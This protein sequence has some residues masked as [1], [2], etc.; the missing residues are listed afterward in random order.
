MLMYYYILMLSLFMLL[1]YKL[2]FSIGE[3]PENTQPVNTDFLNTIKDGLQKCLS[4]SIC[5]CIN[6]LFTA[7][8][9]L[10]FSQD[11]VQLEEHYFSIT[12]SIDQQQAISDFILAVF[13]A[14]STIALPLA[15]N[16]QT[17]AYNCTNQ[18]LFV[19]TVQA[20][21]ELVVF[22][23][24]L[25]LVDINLQVAISDITASP[26]LEALKL[27]GSVILGDIKFSTFVETK[28]PDM[29]YFGAI[30][31]GDSGNGVIKNGEFNLFNFISSV[32]DVELPSEPFGDLVIISNVALNGRMNIAA[33][34]DLILIIEATIHIGEWYDDRVCV[35]LH[36]TLQ[37]SGRSPPELAFLTGCDSF[38]SG[39]GLS[40]SE[41]VQGLIDIDISSVPFFGSLDLP[42]FHIV[43]T[44]PKFDLVGADFG[45]LELPDFG[46]L[47]IGD[48]SGFHF[49]F[50]FHIDSVNLPW[51]ISYINGSL[52]LKPLSLIKGFSISDVLKAISSTVSLPDVDVI[53]SA[54]DG[55]LLTNLDLDVE[56]KTFALRIEVPDAITIFF[57][58]LQV[59]DLVL[60][61]ELTWEDGISFNRLNMEGTLQIG[62]QTFVTSINFK[63]SVYTLSA[64]APDFEGGIGGIASALSSSLS[65][66]IA[67]ST[68]GF[69]TIG[70]FEPCI[71]VQFQAGQFPEYM[72]FS[73]VL[74]RS[75][76]A[77][78]SL[79]FC[80]TQDRE[81]VFGLEVREFVFAT[82]LAQIIGSSGRQIALFNQQLDTAII[83]SP[84]SVKGLPLRGGLIEEIDT[85]LQ[86][87]TILART[88][89]PENCDSDAFCSVA[90]GLLGEDS[91]LYLLIHILGKTVTVRATVD[92]FMLGSFTLSSASIEMMFSPT[93]FSV[94]I[95]AEMEISDPPITL[96]GAFRLNF[97]QPSL[98][99]EMFMTGCWENAFGISILDI[100]DYFI[101]V[102]ITPGSPY[103]GVAF[104]VTVKIGDER[105]YVLEQ[106]GFFSI[107]PNNPL[108][109]YFYVSIS[110][111]TF[112]RV[113]D[114][115]CVD[116][117]LPSFLG[118]TGFPEGFTTS[119][120]SVEH[121][122]PTLG[123]AIPAGFYFDGIINIFGL[124]VDCEMVLN[125]PEIID[126]YVRLN[127]LTM[128]GGLLKL[129]ESREVTDRGPFL[130]V[131]VQS[132][133]QLFTAEASGYVSVLGIQI[134]AMLSV[135]DSGYEISVYG[136][137]FGVLEAEL[138]IKASI[139]NV[140]DASYSAAGKISTTIQQDIQDAV[141]GLIDG[142]GEAANKA[143][144]EAQATLDD[145]EDAFDDAV[146]DLRAAERKVRNARNEVG[147]LRG[148]IRKLRDGL[149]EIKSCRDGEFSLLGS[150]AHVY[151]SIS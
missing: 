3:I 88:S 142:A 116:L 29:W 14:D 72:C 69:D 37:Q 84:I 26:Q 127:P 68:F 147:S 136:N 101:S 59:I 5:S 99:L 91:S 141:V 63:D 47:S 4:G 97:P 49:N 139:G 8:A 131:V 126:V 23:N 16:L 109:N 119:Y 111:L 25:T 90:R 135:S 149:C 93:V 65:N 32:F 74:F 15:A 78:I 53:N 64:C 118:D 106:T 31:K 52:K 33:N 71:D 9:N 144:S 81:W 137:I 89:W 10:G 19:E 130:H 122:L 21:G 75:E 55:I 22:P 42:E 35:I 117:T 44:T 70:L 12:F 24:I 13:G 38:G 85:I 56:G 104:G 128:G 66:S 30:L 17:M 92:N 61:F 76:F 45:D 40:L 46:D 7:I 43:Y 77:D 123:I 151:M 62:S 146:A 51:S 107:N 98:T 87:T 125:P 60:D 145:A 82:L 108:D 83:V 120:A 67:V 94:G 54:L 143:F 112:Q 102:T 133:P 86:G 6:D 96:G 11:L 148:E 110:S 79:S 95:V 2:V 58:D 48:I 57:D 36:Q 39:E 73:A 113:V 129:Y 140:L 34:F 50:N 27:V 1:S 18:E 138:M 121:V 28:D 115:F 124:I 20:G 134:E 41:V 114:L 100:C 132:T 105:C 80:I 103:P 150:R